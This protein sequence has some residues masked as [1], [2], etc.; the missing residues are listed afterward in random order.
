MFSVQICSEDIES[1][2]QKLN[3]VKLQSYHKYCKK[4]K[5]KKR[6]NSRGFQMDCFLSLF[7]TGAALHAYIVVYTPIMCKVHN[8]ERNGRKFSNAKAKMTG[9]ISSLKLD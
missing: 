5:K 2:L 8:Y 7:L 3:F 9:K 6:T 4:K 1:C